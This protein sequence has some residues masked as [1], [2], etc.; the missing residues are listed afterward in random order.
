VRR[1]IFSSTGE[2]PAQAR[3]AA[4]AAG[5]PSFAGGT[6]VAG[7]RLPVRQLT[8]ATGR[9]GAINI[10]VAIG[11]DADKSRRRKMTDQER[12]KSRVQ[13]IKKKVDVLKGRAGVRYLRK[14]DQAEAGAGAAG[15]ED[16][17]E[18]EPAAGSRQPP[19]REDENERGEAQAGWAFKRDAPSRSSGPR[20]SVSDDARAVATAELSGT[21]A[22]A[23]SQQLLDAAQEFSW[24][25][26]NSQAVELLQLARR[27]ID[28]EQLERKLDAVTAQ[29]LDDQCLWQ[30]AAAYEELGRL[31]LAFNTYDT[32]KDR[33]LEK[34]EQLR[35]ERS[36]ASVAY[37][38]AEGLYMAR[39]FEECLE[40]LELVLAT[41]TKTV[42]GDRLLEEFELYQA[43]T[44]QSLGRTEEAKQIL[45]DVRRNTCS[46]KRKAQ[47]SFV[48]DVYSVEESGERNEEFHKV[49]DQSFRL[50]RESARAQVRMGSGAGGLNLSDREREWRSWASKYWEER[51]KSPL[52]YAFLTL[53]VTWPFAIP[54]VSILKKMEMGAV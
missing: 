8:C 20:G 6:E 27:R 28:R 42:T 51:L 26:E 37:K 41:T 36:W 25:R 3:A 18:A 23:T 39:R 9:P 47:A 22:L 15:E 1:R 24:A 38:L 50:P 40:V 30:L 14:R 2:L 44:L 35:A 7:Q 12:R 53:W 5:L 54:V 45:L 48:L 31:T 13:E 33:L 11:K 16:A 10:A 43:M 29:R 52:Y 17:A 49:W 34:S 21:S 32:L 46:K 4:T 19:Q